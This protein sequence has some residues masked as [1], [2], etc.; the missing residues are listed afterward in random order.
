MIWASLL[1]LIINDTHELTCMSIPVF[2]L[3]QKVVVENHTD[4]YEYA[5]G[6]VKASPA[7]CSLASVYTLMESLFY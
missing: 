6:V 2:S 3:N 7:K 4:I 1:I 5:P